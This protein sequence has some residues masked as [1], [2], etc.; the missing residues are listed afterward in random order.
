MWCSA[1]RGTAVPSCRRARGSVSYRVAFG[2][3][4]CGMSTGSSPGLALTLFISTFL[5]LVLRTSHCWPMETGKI[6][7]EILAIIKTTNGEFGNLLSLRDFPHRMICATKPLFGLVAALSYERSRLR[8][9]VNSNDQMP[10]N[11]TITTITTIFKIV[12]NISNN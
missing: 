8:F 5:Y 9:P 6:K 3:V 1:V 2:P 11:D 12:N 7:K 4:S 10:R